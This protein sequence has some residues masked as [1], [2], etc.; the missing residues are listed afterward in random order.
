MKLK[1]VSPIILL[2]S[3]T[4]I[5]ES[6]DIT[7]S[8]KKYNTGPFSEFSKCSNNNGN[9]PIPHDDTVVYIPWEEF[10]DVTQ[11]KIRMGK[12]FSTNRDEFGRKISLISQTDSNTGLKRTFEGFLVTIN[13]TASVGY[14]TGKLQPMGTNIEGKGKMKQVKCQKTTDTIRNRGNEKL[15][16]MLANIRWS[17]STNDCFR[18]ENENLPDIMF[19][20]FMAPTLDVLSGGNIWYSTS[21]KCANVAQN[22]VQETTFQP[23]AVSIDVDNDNSNE[24]STDEDSE[25]SSTL[26]DVPVT[27]K[28][29][30]IDNLGDFDGIEDDIQLKLATYNRKPVNKYERGSYGLRM[31]DKEGR[32]EPEIM[33]WNKWTSWSICSAQ[34]GYGEMT[35]TRECISSRT[36]QPVSETNCQGLAKH[37]TKCIKRKCPEWANWQPWGSCSRKCGAGHKTRKR[38]CLYG[39]NCEGSDHETIQC[40][41]TDCHE[42]TRKNQQVPTTPTFEGKCENRYSFCEHWHKKG[43]CEHRFTK[44]MSINCPVVCKKCEKKQETCVDRYPISC[45]RWK[46]QNRCAHHDVFLREYIVRNCKLSCGMCQT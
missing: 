6:T 33:D 5:I 30:K 19:Q 11:Y 1:Y 45:P 44:W 7:I 40:Q 14:S 22:E 3:S 20:V 27:L 26:G 16:F 8:G 2:S 46:A 24:D 38:I 34:C 15:D 42:I 9:G 32:I 21:F 18:G 35:R 13:G 36:L 25:D 4:S 28:F 37:T 41:G 17:S 31:Y 29:A 10:Q 39:Q 23:A 43:Y 12:D